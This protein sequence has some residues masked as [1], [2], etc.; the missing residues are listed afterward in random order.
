MSASG[1]CFTGVEVATGGGVA[2][3]GSMPR[4]TA[5]RC[6]SVAAFSKR[7]LISELGDRFWKLLGQRRRLAEGGA[8]GPEAR[9]SLSLKPR[10]EDGSKRDAEDDSEE[11]VGA[12]TEPAEPAQDGAERK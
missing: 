2:A 8:L 10:E 9:S 3:A 6:C 4:P 5:A 12:A 1:S 11:A 7:F